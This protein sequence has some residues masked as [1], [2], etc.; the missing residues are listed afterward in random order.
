MSESYILSIDQST[1][2]TK[3]LLFDREGQ[4]VARCDLPHEQISP[5]PGWVEHDPEEIYRNVI[6]VSYTHLRNRKFPMVGYPSLLRLTC[7]KTKSLF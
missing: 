4:L 2:G 6:P 7:R 3:S 1:S 5:Q